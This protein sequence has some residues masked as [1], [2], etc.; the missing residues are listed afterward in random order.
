MLHDR[1]HHSRM[2]GL[3]APYYNQVIIPGLLLGDIAA[4]EVSAVHALRIIMILKYLFQ[5]PRNSRP[6]LRGRDLCALHLA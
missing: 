6:G 2:G 3:R 1:P 5:L 4:A